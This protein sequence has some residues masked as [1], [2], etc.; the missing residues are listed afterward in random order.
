[1]NAP[2]VVIGF[3][4]SFAAVETAWSLQEAG[5]RVVAFTR[6]GA[7]SA[8][9]R[10]RGVEI[11][12]VAAPEMSIAASESDVRAVITNTE[13][14]AV[15]PLDDASL[16]LLDRI[17]D[18]PKRRAFPGGEG[19]ALALDKG[20]QMAAARAAGLSVPDTLAVD[21]AAK[22]R[23]RAPWPAV[24][25]PSEAVRIEGERI[26]RPRGVVCLDDRELADA[27]PR[28]SG[29]P[30]LHQPLIAGTGEG[31]F[32]FVSDGQA[33]A[34]S[35]HRR[36]RMVN[37]QGSASSACVS[38]PVD[39]SLVDPIGRMLA[40]VR[41][42]GLFMI[43]FLRDAAGTPWFMEINGRTWGSLALARRRG[44]E[45]PAWVVQELLGVP[46]APRPPRIEPPEIVARHL[47][48][49]IA[50]LLF[51]LRGPQSEAITVWPGRL[52]TVRDLLRIG[53]GQRLY[54]WNA[55]NPTV[56][57]SDTFTTL[58]ELVAGARKSR[59]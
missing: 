22:L 27:L 50:H 2:T 7:R 51:V 48:R 9:S 59:A 4:E 35:A 24:V 33:V 18:E 23:D 17:V 47:G 36:V 21:D 20:A 25:K 14:D 11:H 58:T 6:R 41:W 37:P 31:I 8:L 1:M 5:M 38:Q 26:G 45:Y 13:P 32:G 29:V 54:N 40:S 34:L 46:Q 55:R 30:V 16:W 12:H 39:E 19:V 56:L 44:L 43:E 49:E 28:L 57:A 3:A 42:S 15:L 53:P 10:V 52:Q